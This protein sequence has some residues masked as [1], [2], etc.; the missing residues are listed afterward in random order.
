MKRFTFFLFVLLIGCNNTKE[1]PILSYKINDLGERENYTIT[2]K[3]FENQLGESFSTETIKDKIFI[4]N[5]FFTKCPS[6][7]PPMKAQLAAI[8]DAFKNDSDFV[9]ISH[10]IDPK[11]DTSVTLKGYAETTGIKAQKWQFVRSSEENTRLQA[12]QFMTNFK[13]NEDGTDFYHSSYVALVDKNQMIRGFYNI[14]ANEDV[15]RLKR[16]ISNLLS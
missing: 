5:F 15:A 3:G 1:L 6:I 7:C 14:L 9:I 4:A 13:P 12:N 10:T 11:H 16:D 2:Y 8:A